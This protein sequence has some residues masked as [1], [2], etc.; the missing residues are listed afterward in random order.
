LGESSNNTISYNNVYNNTNYGLEIIPDLSEGNTV[1]WNNFVDNNVGFPVRTSQA[2]DSGTMN[3]FTA[4]YW[5]DWNG[6]GTYDILPINGAP[7][8]QDLSPLTI[9][10]LPTVN[11][12]TPIAWEYGTDTIT[13]KLSGSPTILYYKYYIEVVDSQNLSWTAMVDRTLPDDTYTLYAYGRD[14]LG[15]IV[16]SSVSFTIDAMLPTIDITSPINR[17]YSLIYIPLTYSI[18]DGSATIYLNGFA[19]TTAFPSGFIISDFPDIPTISDGSFN[20]TIVAMDKAGN[21]VKDTVTFSIDTTPPTV[22][23]DS[24]INT[25]YFTST[26]PVILDGDAVYYWYNIENIDY[27]NQTWLPGISRSLA[28]GT[29][30]LLA[31]GNDSVGNIGHTS[32]TFIINTTTTTITTTPPTLIPT[33]TTEETSE[34]TTAE[35][36]ISAPSFFTVLLFLVTLVVIRRYKKSF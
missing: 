32:V 10:L 35:I 20:I 17:T 30:T 28:D 6:S 9:S 4:N 11:I 13:V 24:P 29:Y 18:L 33:T 7:N 31:F 15:N 12:V 34:V 19:N 8:N 27:R 1:Y 16:Y 25:T 26:I 36:T 2:Y 5:N 3:N 22:I 14:I 23:I 21:I